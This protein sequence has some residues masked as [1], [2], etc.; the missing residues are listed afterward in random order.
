MIDSHAR[1]ERAVGD[2]LAAF[3]LAFSAE[4]QHIKPLA[5]GIR[6]QIYAQ[7]ALSH[8]DIGDALRRY[9]NRA[10]YLR[11]IIEGAARVDLDGATS[12]NVTAM[13]AAYAAERITT[14]LAVG[15]GE[16]KDTI[17]PNTP[18]HTSAEADISQSP[19]NREASKR[20]PRQFS[21]ADLRQA[22]AARRASP[23]TVH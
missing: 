16:P 18:A 22:A 6:Q 8:R 15:A 23:L 19:A 10:A 1:I 7:S 2:L 13:E 12:G 21:L 14:G 11:T 20:G 17:E 5:I 9:T 3:P 4:P